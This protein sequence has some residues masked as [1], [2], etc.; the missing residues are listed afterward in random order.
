M[1]EKRDASRKIKTEVWAYRGA[2]G[3]DLAMLRKTHLPMVSICELENS[4]I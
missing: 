2:S 4:A 1:A 3:W